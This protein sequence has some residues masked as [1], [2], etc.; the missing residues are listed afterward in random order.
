MQLALQQAG[1]CAADI[2][3]INLHATGTQ[4][5]DEAEMRAMAMVFPPET[6]CSG[7]KGLTGHTLGAAGGVEAIISLLSLQHDFLPGTCGLKQVDPDFSS[8]VVYTSKTD[9]RVERVMTNN[10][11]FGGNN[12]TLIFGKAS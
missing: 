10:F 4:K 11:G 7:T 1:L 5:N 6:P 12:T 8:N 2:D 3:Y 9:V